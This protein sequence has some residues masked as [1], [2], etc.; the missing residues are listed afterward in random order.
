MKILVTGMSGLIGRAIRKDLEGDYDLRALNRSAIDGVDCVQADIS[1]FDAIRPAFD[2]V[3]QVVHM[4]AI[5]H[6]SPEWD[7]LLP[8]NV[9]GTYNVFEAAKQAGVR[10]VIYASSGA[11]ISGYELSEPYKALGEG[12]YDD[13]TEWDDL[14]HLSPLHPRGIY[15]CTKVWAEA[16]ARHYSD[17]AGMS[18]IGLRIGAV[19]EEDRPLQARHHSVYCS[20][21]DVAR[22]VR[23]CI[24]TEVEIQYDIFF[25]VSNN[26]YSYRD[27]NHAKKVL[28]FEPRDSA[29]DRVHPE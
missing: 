3:D 12:R 10:R 13:V 24:E 11:T 8:F 16:L 22:M 4:A 25:V 18:M 2:G 21:G 6:G 15:G 7:K 1:H 14:T 19:N 29:D 5:A 26:R 9:I 20:Q 17:S 23:T 27:M 28:G